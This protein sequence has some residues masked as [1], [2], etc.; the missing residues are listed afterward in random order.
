MLAIKFF[1][2]LLLCSLVLSH[3]L[4]KWRIRHEEKQQVF[5]TNPLCICNIIFATLFGCQQQPDLNKIKSQVK[6]LNDIM[7]KAVLENDS[8]TMLKLYMEDG[9]SMPSYEPM[10]KGM[11][12]LKRHSEKNKD[13]PMKMN[14]FSLNST[15]VWASGNFV[16]DIGTYDLVI[17]MPADQGGVVPDKGKYLTLYEIQKDGSLKI[18]A[19]TWNTDMNPWEEMMKHAGDMAGEKK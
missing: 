13:M 19:D 6:E 4:T 11:D 7:T 15:D 18:K 5:I 8:E 1:L 3:F 12:A 16:V 9:I 10:I 14:S 17:E 2:K